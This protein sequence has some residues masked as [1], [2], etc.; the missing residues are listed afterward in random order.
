V[1]RYSD[2]GLPPGSSHLCLCFFSDIWESYVTSKGERLEP[3]SIQQT[4]F[5]SSAL[6][7]NYNHS[8]IQPAIS[9]IVNSTN[10][11]H[12]LSHLSKMSPQKRLKEH[13]M[14]SISTQLHLSSAKIKMTTP[15]PFLLLLNGFPGVG[16]LTIASKLQDLLTQATTGPIA[17]PQVR[18]LDNH[19]LIDP[20]SAIEPERNA[21]HWRLRKAFRDLAFDALRCVRGE[22][23]VLTT[24]CLAETKE[25]KAQFEE[26]LAVAE[27]RGCV[28]VVLNFVCG[29]E[30][31]GRRLES[32]E[33]RGSV[34]GMVKAKLTDRGLLERFHKV[35]E[36]LDLE[37]LEGGGVRLVCGNI[38]TTDLSEEET[39]EKVWVLLRKRLEF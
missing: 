38:E 18:L 6:S 34:H 20:V 25:G 7:Y 1:N 29:V 4:E 28:L 14:P 35:Y 10:T 12:Y 37:N 21:S 36:L 30:E 13:E 23:I 8:V 16:K 32:E 22:L 27:G 3:F 15:P 31:N 11:R 9:D 24:A 5:I 33:R 39:T 17:G 2:V 19:L 26:F